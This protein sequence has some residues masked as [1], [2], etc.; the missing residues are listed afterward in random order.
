MNE[1]TPLIEGRQLSRHYDKG[2][3]RALE[4]VDIQLFAGE[5]VALHGPSGC[6]KSTLLKTLGAI[7]QP[8]AGEVIV[9][10]RALR[11]WRPMHRY[12]ARQVGFVFQSHYLLPH[13]TL[14][15]N[16]EIPLIAIGM[17]KRPRRE[18]ANHLLAEMSLSHRAG[19]RPTHVSGGERQRAAIAR[20]L[21]TEPPLLLCDE[22]T[23]SLDSE[24]GGLILDVL[25][26]L[27]DQRGTTLLIATH[28]QAISQRTD[29]VLRMRDGRIVA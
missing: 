10:G 17:A 28:D 14:A 3:V 5:A 24:T 9:Q 23:G 13:L 12:R 7:E 21:A 19:F 11:R 26:Q 20:A 15:E 29:R 4:Q 16:I 8:S 22:P 6:G 2:L 18:R 25:L 27:R 1:R